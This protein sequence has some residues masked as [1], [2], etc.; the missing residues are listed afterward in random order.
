MGMTA[1]TDLA[2]FYNLPSW[3]FGSA[4]PTFWGH[5]LPRLLHNLFAAYGVVFLIWQVADAYKQASQESAGGMAASQLCLS[6]VS[7][8]LSE[9][10][11]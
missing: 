8:S 11:W 9:L 6:T 4:T 7:S 5:M 3:G 10:K 1:W 2:R